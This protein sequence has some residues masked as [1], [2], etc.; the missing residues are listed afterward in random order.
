MN[1]QAMRA[2][3]ISFFIII[4]LLFGRRRRHRLRRS[5]QF[6]SQMGSSIVGL[7]VSY[8]FFRVRIS[9]VKARIETEIITHIRLCRPLDNL[10]S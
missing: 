1:H 9:V 7:Y 4:L 3:H 8:A 5:R 6:V 10:F 2:R